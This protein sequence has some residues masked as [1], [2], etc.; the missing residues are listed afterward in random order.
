MAAVLGATGLAGC[1]GILGGGGGGGA[2]GNWIYDP[3]V[4]ASVPNV[5]FG[6]MAY[7]TF[8]DNRDELPQSM[9]EGF[10]TDEDSP[11]Q[12]SD[13]DD[14]AGVAGGDISQDMSS[15]SLF[16]SAVITGSFPRSE[17]ESEIESD[18]GSEPAGSYEGFSLYEATDVGDSVGGVPG[19][20]QFQGT[21]SVAIGDSAMVVGVSVAQGMESDA[22]GEDAVRTMIDASAGNARR[23]SATSGPAQQVQNRIDDSML[24]VGAEVD[25]ALVDL[26]SQMGGGGQMGEQVLGGLRGGGMGADIDGETTTITA[27][28]VYESEQAATEAGVVDLVSGMSGSLEDQEGINSVEA[29]QDG[30]VA[31]IT[32]EGDTETLAEQG[33]GSG[34]NLNVAPRP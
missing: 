29:E 19:S 30:A 10:E 32:I 25:P 12:P 15:A 22:T 6:S 17:L 27:V 13:I 1:G 14:V 16:G 21:G 33:A 4:L 24:S 5:V 7:G 11:V 23:L 18:E 34:T 31:V 20:N 9:Q 28:L 3:N 2:V 26:A 8:Y